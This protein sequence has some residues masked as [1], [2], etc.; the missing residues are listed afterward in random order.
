MKGHREKKEILIK[1]NDKSLREGLY[2]A[3]LT[4]GYDTYFAVNG[5]NALEVTVNRV[6]DLMVVDQ[7]LSLKDAEHFVHLIRS[8][9]MTKNIPILGFF[10]EGEGESDARG[11]AAGI[12]WVP[13]DM[14]KLI[15]NINRL[16]GQEKKA[17]LPE[18]MPAQ[19]RTA[20]EG[21][22]KIVDL[23]FVQVTRVYPEQQHTFDSA[24]PPEETKTPP[25][26]NGHSEDSG[27]QSPRPGNR[28]VKGGRTRN[29]EREVT[30]EK[31][32]RVP[33]HVTGR[34]PA[35]LLASE[36]EM[37]MIGLYQTVDSLLS[38][39]TGKV[40]QFIGSLEGEGVS[41]IT[42]EFAKVSA[43][44]FERSVLLMDADYRNPTQYRYF[45]IL[46]EYGLEEAI[47][48]GQHIDRAIHRVGNTRLYLNSISTNG[49]FNLRIFNSPLVD[50]LLKIL[51]KR[52]DM[53]LIDS[54]PVS[55]SPESLIISSRVDGIVLVMEA[56]NIHWRVVENVKNRIAKNG[57]KVLGIVINKKQYHIPEF[58]YKRL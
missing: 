33:A 9:P 55:V 11:R 34:Y 49:R 43:T 27:K 6:P 22:G 36:M 32:T 19:A 20:S 47:R 16:L 4:M 31:K 14:E 30:E 13:T 5:S 3:L 12:M 37:E 2:S 56:E 41:T 39:S 7:S 17:A 28:N 8:N 48:N 57:G 29:G 35:K 40:I 46:P 10:R 23:E 24:F 51:K 38:S 21:H 58:I 44:R 15:A 18:K 52:F 54:P 42:R 45:D 26:Q 1:S 53:V 50:T 25:F